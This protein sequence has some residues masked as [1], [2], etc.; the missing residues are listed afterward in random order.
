MNKTILTFQK[1]LS[2][3]RLDSLSIY[4]SYNRKKTWWNYSLSTTVYFAIYEFYSVNSHHRDKFPLLISYLE[5]RFQILV[6]Y[7]K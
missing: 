4:E 3:G 7:S 5:S 2:R 6:V 1:D